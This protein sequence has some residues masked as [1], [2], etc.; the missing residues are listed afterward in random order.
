MQ[1]VIKFLMILQTPITN[2][3]IAFQ[4]SKAGLKSN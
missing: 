4:T 3:D 2:K 1:D